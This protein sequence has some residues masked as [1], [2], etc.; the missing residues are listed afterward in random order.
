MGIWE[1]HDKID[2]DDMPSIFGDGEG[3]QFS[4]R[5]ALLSIHLKAHIAGHAILPYIL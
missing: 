3:V 5:S 2:T 1:F 4:K